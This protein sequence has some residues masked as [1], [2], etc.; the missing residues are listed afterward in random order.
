MKKIQFSLLLILFSCSNDE[1]QISEP[2]VDDLY[3]PAIDSDQWETISTDELNW[4]YVKIENLYDFL[5]L[6]NTRAFIILKE[7]RIV[8]ENYW[9]NNI[10]NTAS[11]DRNSNWY[12]ASAGKTLTA[13]LVGIAQDNGLLSIEDS[14][15]IF[16]GNGWTSLEESQES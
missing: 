13:L 3:F 16:L 4:D 6:N 12:W 5:E 11:F 8:L 10:Q 15:S 1:T 2:V 7:G 9:G 14:S